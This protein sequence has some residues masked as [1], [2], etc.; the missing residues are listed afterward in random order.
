M[1]KNYKTE[2]LELFPGVRDGNVNPLLP[3]IFVKTKSKAYKDAFAIDCKVDYSDQPKSSD[4]SLSEMLSLYDE[5]FYEDG[6]IEAGVNMLRHIFFLLLAVKAKKDPTFKAEDFKA[7]YSELVFSLIE[8]DNSA[9][10]YYFF[11]DMLYGIHSL[12]DDCMSSKDED[13]EKAMN[14][15]LDY[16]YENNEYLASFVKKFSDP[17]A[18]GGLR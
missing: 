18:I 7:C 1:T 3:R 14:W 6:V 12:D 17:W 8:K 11:L 15:L 9:G 5:A 10:A 4:A 16:N 13:I 2:M